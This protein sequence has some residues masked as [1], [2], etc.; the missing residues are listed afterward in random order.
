MWRSG[1][2]RFL[3]LSKQRP[4]SSGAGQ[5][6]LHSKKCL[7][8]EI[9]VGTASKR[10]EGFPTW[11]VLLFSVVMK[12]LVGA[13]SGAQCF[14]VMFGLSSTT[15]QLGNRCLVPKHPLQCAG[16]HQWGPSWKSGVMEIRWLYV[17]PLSLEQQQKEWVWNYLFLPFLTDFPSH[18]NHSGC[19]APPDYKGEKKEKKSKQFLD[20]ISVF[21]VLSPSPSATVRV[22]MQP[23]KISLW[24]MR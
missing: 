16:H 12:C 21:I 8:R 17:L 2:T 23:F 6:S 1:S 14:W 19:S 7:L 20:H 5:A 15:P 24:H 22:I 3:C 18:C 13:A 11:W 10:A 4:Q 9:L